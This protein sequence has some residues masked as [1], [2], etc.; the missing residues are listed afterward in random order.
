MRE[1]VFIYGIGSL[2]EKILEYNN[3]DQLFDII[4]FLDDG[5]NLEASFSLLP[6][7]TYSNFKTQYSAEDC[8]IFVAIGYTKCN[9]YRELIVN[10]VL[11]DGYQLINYISPKSIC[12]DNTIIGLNIFIADN[13]FVGHG[14]QIHD[15]VIIYEGCT[16]SHNTKVESYCFISLR[17]ASGGFTKIGHNSFIGVNTTIKDDITIGAYNIVGC[18]TN[19]LKSTNEKN[20]I[21]GNPGIAKQKDTLTIKI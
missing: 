20:V 17:V 21:V 4:G 16:F 14:S 18:G 3:R 12:W 15:G 10:R 7:M 11:S 5:G 8:K 1:K 2:A 19:I 9:Y 6:V 13:V